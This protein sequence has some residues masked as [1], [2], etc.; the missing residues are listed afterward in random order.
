MTVTLYG[1]VMIFGALVAGIGLVMLFRKHEQALSRIKLFGQEFQ[2]S[3]PGLVVSLAGCILFVL[4]PVLQVNDRDVFVIG[5]SSNDGTRRDV[6]VLVGGQEHEPNDNFDKANIVKFG[7]TTQG[8]LTPNDRDFFKFQI[9]ATLGLPKVRVIVEKM[10]SAQAHIYDANEVGVA[11]GYEVGEGPV[12]FSF[13]GTPGAYYYI[14]VEAMSGSDR[15]EYTLI[16][17][18]E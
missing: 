13:D 8:V 1:L 14:V 3:A 4:L 11:S 18:H 7:T 9:P 16:L 6:N 15:G 10:F 2:F 17:K 5:Q 12:S